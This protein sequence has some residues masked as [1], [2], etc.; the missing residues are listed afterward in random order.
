MVVVNRQCHNH[1]DHPIVLQLP[2]RAQSWTEPQSPGAL[3]LEEEARLRCEEFAREDAEKLTH[4][5]SLVDGLLPDELD[6]ERAAEVHRAGA[7]HLCKGGAQE[8]GPAH[9]EHEVEGGGVRSPAAEYHFRLR[10]EDLLLRETLP[11]HVFHLQHALFEGHGHQICVCHERTKATRQHARGVRPPRLVDHLPRRDLAELRVL[12]EEPELDLRRDEAL[13]QREELEGRGVQKA[14]GAGLA[15]HRSC[16]ANRGRRF[17]WPFSCSASLFCVLHA[18]A[19]A[20]ADITRRTADN[21]RVRV[22]RS[23]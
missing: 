7:V 3:G 18:A 23:K 19:V 8:V 1:A 6:A 13:G 9:A 2:S 16:K 11:Q 5:A 15:D 4:H 21:T 12:L 22:H 17:V 20:K 10:P 14:C